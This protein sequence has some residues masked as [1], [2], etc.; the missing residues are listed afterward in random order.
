MQNGLLGLCYLCIRYE[1]QRISDL[2]LREIKSN[3]E[4]IRLFDQK[5]SRALQIE[6]KKEKFMNLKIC[7]Y[8]IY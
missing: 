6:K 8:I 1:V 5:T 3:C 7:P 4:V 2:S